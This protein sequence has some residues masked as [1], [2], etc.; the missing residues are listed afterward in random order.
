MWRI[1]VHMSEHFFN[2]PNEEYEAASWLTTLRIMQHIAER[3]ERNYSVAV[4][5]CHLTLQKPDEAYEAMRRAAVAPTG[6]EPT[7]EKMFINELG[8][9]SREGRIVQGLSDAAAL[10]CDDLLA[11]HVKEQT[12][13]ERLIPL[14]DE[15]VDFCDDKYLQP[16][17]HE[18]LKQTSYGRRLH[19]SRIEADYYIREYDQAQN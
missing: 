6:I 9:V 19:F 8:A 13:F 2:N 7:A 11:Q 10:L 15:M 14:V 1:F 12:P 16:V 5:L 17:S 4:Q 3:T 18:S